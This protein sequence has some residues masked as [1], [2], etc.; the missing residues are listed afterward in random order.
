[1]VEAERRSVL[2]GLAAAALCSRAVIAPSSAAAPS[3]G[4]QAPAFYRFRM[5]N[6]EITQVSDGVLNLPLADAFAPNAKRDEVN[7]ALEKAFL[8]QDRMTLVFNPS[9][10][11]TGKRLVV[12]DTGRGEGR[13]T[14]GLFFENMA[15]AGIDPKSVDTVVISH[16]H[17]D[18]INGLVRAD[19][20]PTFP[21]A[22]IM[23]SATESEFWMDDGNMARAND[24]L[25]L[26]F[27]NVRRVMAAIQSQL[28]F[29]KNE[30][31]I[32][33]G[34][35]A[36]ATPGHTPGHTSFVLQS[37]RERLLI[38]SDIVIQ[39]IFVRN[40]EWFAFSDLNGPQAVQTRRRFYDMAAA[41]RLPLLGY[42]FPFPSIGHIAK[43]ESHYQF[44]PTAWNPTL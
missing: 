44:I 2:S 31:E 18:H 29:Y 37:G 39:D 16:F 15:A 41:E 21:N 23:V 22:V 33:S 7:A 13:S 6:Y 35:I 8:P 34:I 14:A 5:G 9:I 3:S 11:N 36:V 4:K 28:A 38:Q 25:V 26:N 1:M 19:G 12:I 10:V 42:H 24:R 43:E 27:K 32:E 40:P 17:S 30:Q 20:A